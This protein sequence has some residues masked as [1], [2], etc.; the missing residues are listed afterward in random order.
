MEI[1][2]S[3]RQTIDIYSEEDYNMLIY[4]MEHVHTGTAGYMCDGSELNIMSKK[5]T[6]SKDELEKFGYRFIKQVK[7]VE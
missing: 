5:L 2:K 4:I 1:K 3:F 7:D 6:Y